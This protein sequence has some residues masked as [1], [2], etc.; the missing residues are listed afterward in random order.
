MNKEE[1]AWNPNTPIETLIELSKDDNEDVRRGVASNIN[2]PI[3]T[4]NLLSKDDD[5]WVR[6]GVTLN[7]IWIYSSKL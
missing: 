6:H 2:T 4:L 5:C 3:E 7:P 1:L